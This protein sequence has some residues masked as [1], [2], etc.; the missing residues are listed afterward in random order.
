MCLYK[1]HFT[2]YPPSVILVNI[3][4]GE[5]RQSAAWIVYMSKF[6]I[7]VNHTH[8]TKRLVWWANQIY[9]ANKNAVTDCMVRLANIAVDW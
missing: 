2:D 7:S 5:W 1:E 4:F 8:K 6:S 3:K 9:E